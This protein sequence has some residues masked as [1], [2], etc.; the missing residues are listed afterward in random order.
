MPVEQGKVRE[1]ARAT[2]AG[3][4]RFTADP[5]PFLPPTFL[6]TNAFWLAPGSWVLEYGDLDWAR[7]LSGGSEFTF[8]GP[9]LR[10]G[11]RLTATQR[12][13]EVYR[14][15][16]RRGGD[17]TFIVFTTT[18]AR[19]DGSVAARERHTTIV[20]GRPPS[21]PAPS[22]PAPSSPAR[23][24]P[25][26]SSL[27]RSSPAP[28]PSAAASPAPSSPAPVSPL[29][30]QERRPASA[31]ESAGVGV[32][33]PS[34]PVAI[35]GGAAS[36]RP[37][38]SP[39]PLVD[40]PVS[41]TDIVRYQGASGDMNP[42]H[43]DPE[44]AR[45]AGFPTVFSVGML[46][47]GIFGSYLGDLFGAEN[48]RR[49]GVQFREQVWPGDV[50]T[51]NARVTARRPG[52]DGNSAELDLALTARRHLGGEHLRGHATVLTSHGRP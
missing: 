11:E 41:V 32:P 49:F 3:D 51:Y 10:A 27:A 6:V 21:S 31:D 9:P 15:Q 26:S 33:A 13:D 48:V 22:S 40:E 52:P 12:V 50:L 25:A 24:S 47:A 37:G 5:A 23:S 34:R 19:P 14:K 4:E 43:H 39:P 44:V 20:S 17:M 30:A 42:I 18:F 8:S 36:L 2:K 7:L 35:P 45:A 1:F 16:G 46:H 38:D 28:S 29:S